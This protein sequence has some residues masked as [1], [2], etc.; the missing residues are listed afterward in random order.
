MP[1]L[2]LHGVLQLKVSAYY[3]DNYRHTVTCMYVQ[4]FTNFFFA[5]NF[6]YKLLLNK[7]GFK[8]LFYLMYLKKGYI[9]V[10]VKKKPLLLFYFS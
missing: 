5:M 3:K 8:V 4:I 1:Y 9:C 7:I 10:M 6:K 2:C